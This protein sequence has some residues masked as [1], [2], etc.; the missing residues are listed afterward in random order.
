MPVRA[1]AMRYRFWSIAHGINCDLTRWY[2]SLV[3]SRTAADCYISATVILEPA[4]MIFCSVGDPD[5]GDSSEQGGFG[6]YLMMQLYGG[7]FG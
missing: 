3:L 1:G 4:W 2:V 7:L 5:I 6:G